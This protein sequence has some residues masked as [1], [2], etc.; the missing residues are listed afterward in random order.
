M[1]LF[2]LW[3]GSIS[4]Q[5]IHLR[6]KKTLYPFCL[7]RRMKYGRTLVNIE[8]IRENLKFL[9]VKKYIELDKRI[10]LYD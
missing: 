7:R 1:I 5:S 10:R 2:L 9:Y 8:D 4:S 6:V 3:D